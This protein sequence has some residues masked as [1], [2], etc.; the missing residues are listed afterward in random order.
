MLIP[1]PLSSFKITTW[2]SSITQK[3]PIRISVLHY[4]CELVDETRFAVFQSI[5]VL[6]ILMLYMSPRGP[7]LPFA[8]QLSSFMMLLQSYFVKAILVLEP[9]VVS[10][11]SG[12][13]GTL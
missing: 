8:C 6:P 10:L 4:Y 5:T 12:H 7:P 13:D 3:S 11:S 2:L 1:F 9:D